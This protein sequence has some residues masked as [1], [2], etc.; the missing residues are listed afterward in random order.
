MD[1]QKQPHSLLPKENSKEIVAGVNDLTNDCMDI[2]ND[3]N[4]HLCANDKQN[5][6]ASGKVE[7]RGR[8]TKDD[9]AEVARIRRFLKSKDRSKSEHDLSGEGFMER[10]KDKRKKSINPKYARV[11]RY[12]YTQDGL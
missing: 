4:E 1:Q 11:P 10:R 12:V 7:G 8:Q 6:V 5:L 2:V 9:S 3:D